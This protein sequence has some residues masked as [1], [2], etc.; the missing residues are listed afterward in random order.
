[1]ADHPASSERPDAD[2]AL[3]EACRKGDLRR[4]EEVWPLAKL[5]RETFKSV[6]RRQGPDGVDGPPGPEFEQ[7]ENVPHA[8]C[9]GGHLDVIT[10]LVEKQ[11]MFLDTCG[12]L[13]RSPLKIA[14][15]GGHTACARVLGAICPSNVNLVDRDGQTPFH[16]ACSK[17]NIE[18]LIELL[19]RYG[20]DLK[21]PSTQWLRHEDD[22]H[23]SK[24]RLTPFAAAVLSDSR[25]A[26]DCLLR[27]SSTDF[28]TTVECTSCAEGFELDH[29]ELHC[30]DPLECTARK[31]LSKVKRQRR[32][33]PVK[34]RAAKI[35][36]ALPPTPAGLRDRIAASTEGVLTDDLRF[37]RKEMQRHE[38]KC[39]QKIER[40]EMQQAKESAKY[41]RYC[42]RSAAC[43]TRH[44]NKN[45]GVCC[46]RLYTRRE[47]QH[48]YIITIV[49]SDVECRISLLCCP[50]SGVL[51]SG[52]LA[53]AAVGLA[54]PMPALAAGTSPGP[55]TTTPA[56][57]S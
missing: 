27:F 33:A 2:T 14:C 35:G 15:G 38:K 51:F 55:T 26:V 39:Q 43:V 44:R 41:Q 54:C 37:A 11:H 18:E 4:V 32:T 34:D 13:G 47:S 16:V 30:M 7:F 8:A 57:R 29:C 1:M 40:A 52:A 10:Y 28:E 42:A 46:C 48:S 17:G 9:A 50:R 23:W 36:L 45:K 56:E 12:A 24:V 3:L 22:G 21:T 49:I 6:V 31:R 5:P 19:H 25:P 20:A 53:P